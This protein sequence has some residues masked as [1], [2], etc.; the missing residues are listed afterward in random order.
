MRNNE[1]RIQS[2]SSKATYH[3][4]AAAAAAAGIELVMFVDQQARVHRTLQLSWPP[5]AMPCRHYP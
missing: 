5:E 4:A 2:N 3:L 1:S